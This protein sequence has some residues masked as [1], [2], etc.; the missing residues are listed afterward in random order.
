MK[1]I[2]QAGLCR[3]GCHSPWLPAGWDLEVAARPGLRSWGP[4]MRGQGC[5]C[6]QWECVQEP[7]PG[8][9]GGRGGVAGRAGLRSH[10]CFWIRMPWHTWPQS[11]IR[12]GESRDP[13]WGIHGGRLLSGSP[14][15]VTAWGRGFGGTGVP[16]WLL[17]AWPYS[18]RLQSPHLPAGGEGDGEGKDPLRV[19]QE[20]ATGLRCE[21]TSWAPSTPSCPPRQ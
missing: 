14:A 15:G 20:L 17:P 19:T 4:E 12:V 1:Q 16:L 6:A 18:S 2:N 21:A 7:R 8:C 5:S 9:G 11:R 3:R 10:G 13:A